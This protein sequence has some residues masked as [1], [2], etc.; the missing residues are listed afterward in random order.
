MGFGGVDGEERDMG[1]KLHPGE[2]PGP[3]AEMGDRSM[4]GGPLGSH[5]RWG[6]E[7]DVGKEGTGSASWDMSVPLEKI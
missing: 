1:G 7:D 6:W 3:G 4:P 2:L 5:P